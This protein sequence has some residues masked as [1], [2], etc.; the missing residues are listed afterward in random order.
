MSKHQLAFP[1]DVRNIGGKMYVID[2]MKMHYKNLNAVKG[3]LSLKFKPKKAKR[4]THDPYKDFWDNAEVFY[5][6]KR[7]AERKTGDIDSKKPKTFG[8]APVLS[9]RK[10]ARQANNFDHHRVNV[11]NMLRRMN[12]LGSMAD[13]K[14]NPHDPIAYPV[15]F[16]RRKYDS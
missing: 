7:V 12:E 10:K 11:E 3:T 5:T 2:T 8:M 9:M 14:R 4:K 15:T 1:A 13:R 16:L 6:Q